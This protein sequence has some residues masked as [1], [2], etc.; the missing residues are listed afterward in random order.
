MTEL[1]L[2][3]EAMCCSTGV[4]GPD[5]DDELVEVSAALD[6]LEDAFDDL[7]VTRANMQH[8]I[9][10]FLETQRIYDRV[11]ENGPSVL[12]ITVV[13]GEVVAEGEYLSYDELTAAVGGDA[14]TQEA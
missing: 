3:E 2:Y 8:N 9:D 13:D 5:P 6:Q 11:Q 7:E 4:C 14:A 10:Q 1:T 12:P